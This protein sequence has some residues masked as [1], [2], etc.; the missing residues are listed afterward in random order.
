[1]QQARPPSSSH[2]VPGESRQRSHHLIVTN[3]NRCI[4]DVDVYI[5]KDS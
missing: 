4:R 1:M 3:Q 2:C 5:E